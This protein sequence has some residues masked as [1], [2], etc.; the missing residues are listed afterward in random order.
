MAPIAPFMAEIAC[1]TP[2]NMVELMVKV[3]EFINVEQTIRSFA[4]QAKR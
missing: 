4:G 1:K 2:S 3:E